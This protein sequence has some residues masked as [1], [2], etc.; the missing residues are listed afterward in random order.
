[1]RLTKHE[2]D[3]FVL[4]EGRVHNKNNAMKWYLIVTSYTGPG[5]SVGPGPNNYERLVVD[6]N[7]FTELERVYKTILDFFGWCA[8]HLPIYIHS[9][10]F[11]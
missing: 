3:S 7:C 9:S 1:M 10:C 2:E 4:Q 11:P 5:R 6:L 8:M